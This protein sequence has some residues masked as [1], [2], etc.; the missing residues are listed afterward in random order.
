MANK[1]RDAKQEQLDG[2]RQDLTDTHLTTQQ[3]VRVDHTDDSL[4]VG[5]RG[6]TLLED[7]HARE[8]ITHFD[9]ER[10]PERVVHARGAGAYGHFQPYSDWLADYTVAKFL[11]DPEV[12]T[13]VF[14]RFSTVAGSR[15][16]AD[17]V[18]DVRGFA[19]KFYTEQGNYDLVANN[20]PVFF[21]QDGIKFPDFVHAVK[22]QPD[23]EIPQAASAHNT[24]WD[25][26]Q[27][28]PETLHTVMWLMSDRA[29]PRSYRMMQG[30]GVHTFRFVNAEGKGTFVKFHWKPALGTHSLVWDECQKI[31]GKDPDYN[32]RDLWDAIEAGQYPEYELG[33]QLVDESRE[34]DFDFDLLDPTKII[35]EEEVPVQPVGKLVLDRNPDNFFAE[36]E[37]VAFH[38]ANVVPGIDFTNDPLLQARNFSYL[39]TQLIRL[40]GPNFAQIPINRPVVEVTNN[41]RDGYGQQKIHRGRTSYYNNSLSGGSP[42]PASVEEGAFRH[43]QEKVEGHKIRKRSASFQDHYSQPT[44]FWNSMADWEKEHIVAAFQFELGKCDE[45]HIRENVVAHLNHIDHELAVRVAEGIGVA[46]PREAARPNHGRSSPALSQANTVMDTI[47]TRKIAV[48]AADG[49][50]GREVEQIRQKMAEHDATAEVLAPRDGTLRSSDGSQVDVD[51]LLNTAA[52]VVYDA[53]IVPGGEQSVRTLSEDGYAVHFV[54]E[55]YKHAKP[56]AGSDEGMQL[57]RR[58][59]VAEAGETTGSG[60]GEVHGHLGVVT[61]ATGGELPEDFFDEFIAALRKH[62]VWQRRTESVPA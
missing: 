13:P 1:D 8:K 52:S 14:V 36:T 29:L 20:F 27:L 40:G 39:D 12:R 59:G 25:F 34:F 53:V 17:T 2:V 60:D 48:L 37:Q 49:V 35:P 23:N 22:P 26:V 57:L 21:V 56:V 11:T 9:H 41:Q 46:P 31:A 38:T 44:L 7:F 50:D 55:A 58:A 43:Y 32:R 19:T 62:R 24:F 30:F 45:H 47:A 16:S 3:G 4:T 54:A 33:V 42:A 10:I 51:V 61:A 5:E 15:G 28:N 6:P 18:R